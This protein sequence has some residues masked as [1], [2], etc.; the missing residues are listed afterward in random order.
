MRALILPGEVGHRD[1]LIELEFETRFRRNLDLLSLRGGLNTGA[2][3]TADGGSD[4]RA[5]AAASDG[6]DDGSEGGSSAD[7]FRGAFAARG[8]G[9][10]IFT[11]D[12][13]VGFSLEH[14]AHEFERQFAA[15]RDMAGRAGLDELHVHIGAPRDYNFIVNYDWRIERGLENFSRAIL[16]GVNGINRSNGHKRSRRDFNRLG[17]R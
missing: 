4:C 6:A 15:A 17:L 10:A 3:C 14:H 13:V 7:G 11:A 5:L 1:G 16:R 8:A 9:L 2:A 12:Q